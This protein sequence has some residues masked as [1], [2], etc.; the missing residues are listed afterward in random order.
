M[1]LVVDSARHTGT[2]VY[3][4]TYSVSGLTD[5]FTSGTSTLTWGG[6]NADITNGNAYRLSFSLSDLYYNG[7]AEPSLS[8]SVSITVTDGNSG[9]LISPGNTVSFQLVSASEELKQTLEELNPDIM[10]NG[11]SFVADDEGN[12]PGVYIQNSASNTHSIAARDDGNSTIDAVIRVPSDVYFCVYVSIADA[13]TLI[14]HSNITV[15]ISKRDLSTGRTV[16]LGSV[17]LTEEGTSKYVYFNGNRIASQ[18]SQPSNQSN[19]IHCGDGEELIITFT[20]QQRS[21]W[22]GFAQTMTVSAKLVQYGQ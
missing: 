21:T 22:F 14:T 6:G 13:S 10:E 11:M 8:L 18:D 9:S 5:T 16:S 12:P 19:H 2:G 20:G 4:V 7:T 3:S 17:T 15:E 1:F